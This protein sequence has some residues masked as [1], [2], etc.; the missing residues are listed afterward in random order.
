MGR[1]FSLSASG[2][3]QVNGL[4]AF[5]V[6]GEGGYEERRLEDV[7]EVVDVEPEISRLLEEVSEGS[8][9]TNKGWR[10]NGASTTTAR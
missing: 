3:L 8:G 4:P 10:A 5:G 9:R 7:G 6:T 1:S 2:A